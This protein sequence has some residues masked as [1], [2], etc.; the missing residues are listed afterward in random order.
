MCLSW[1]GAE[2]RKT[3]KKG[4]YIRADTSRG[5]TTIENHVLK[6][7]YLSPNPRTLLYMFYMYQNCSETFVT[8]STMLKYTGISSKTTLTKWIRFLNWIGFL[9]VG[10]YKDEDG[11]LFNTYELDHRRIADIYNYLLDVS[12]TFKEVESYWNK[13]AATPEKAERILNERNSFTKA[14]KEI[15]KNKKWFLKSGNSLRITAF[16]F[17]DV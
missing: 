13:K 11:V 10:K 14:I 17:V 12:L 7:P 4:A 5:F 6:M 2:K 3:K 1:Y 15:L 16:I 9:K 8:Y